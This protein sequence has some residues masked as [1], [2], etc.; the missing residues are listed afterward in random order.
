MGFNSAF[1]GSIEKLCDRNHE[2]KGKLPVRKSTV[3]SMYHKTRFMPIYAI[4]TGELKVS[5]IF[6]Y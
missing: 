6:Y 1:K 2:Q 5:F 3:L 4:V